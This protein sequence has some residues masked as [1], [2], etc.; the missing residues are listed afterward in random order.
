M[1]D[2]K[3][4]AD[5]IEVG[6]KAENSKAENT[7]DILQMEVN[8]NKISKVE[9]DKRAAG[10]VSLDVRDILEGKGSEALQVWVRSLETSM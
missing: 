7:S 3:N 10:S 8:T 1:L 6:S 2:V 5:L 4:T 9:L